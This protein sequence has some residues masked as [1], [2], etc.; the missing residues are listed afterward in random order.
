MTLGE[1]VKQYREEHS[2]SVRAFASLV[3][4]SPQSVINI[5]TGIGNNG[6]PMTSTMKTYRKIADGIGMSEQDL[7]NMLSDNVLVNPS[8]NY[9]IRE[10]LLNSPAFRILMDQVDGADE[11][12]IMA[13]AEWLRKQKEANQ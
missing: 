10:E 7:L 3:G 1:F 12:A 6:K 8:S 4:I 5:E 2:L 13:A 11:D 9:A